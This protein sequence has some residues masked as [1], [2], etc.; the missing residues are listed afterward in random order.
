MIW[1]LQ[2]ARFAGCL[3][4]QGQIWKST[5]VKITEQETQIISCLWDLTS[6]YHY[7]CALYCDSEVQTI[8]IIDTTFAHCV[9]Y[10]VA[11][12]G[13]VLKGCGGACS[14]NCH[15]LSISGC[16]CFYCTAR[17]YE[18]FLWV[19]GTGPTCNLTT[20]TFVLC[21]I[22]HTNT[23][24]VGDHGGI[25]V[26]TAF[27]T[28]GSDL[29]FTD[30]RVTGQGAA[31]L[32]RTGSAALTLTRLTVL[33]CQGQ[34][35]IESTRS[36][37]P[38]ISF[39][40]FYECTVT[41]RWVLTGNSS[42]M[43]VKNCVF[44]SN[45]DQKDIGLLSSSVANVFTIENCVFSGGFP[46]DGYIAKTDPNYANVDTASYRLFA[47][48]TEYCPAIPL[49]TPSISVRASSRPFTPTTALT[50]SAKI[51]VSSLFSGSQGMPPS[52]NW[53]NTG[54]VTAS[55]AI[56][57]SDS[58]KDSLPI[59]P[60]DLLNNSAPICR[61]DLPADSAPVQSSDLFNDSVLIHASDV[62][63]DSGPVQS[64]DLFNDSL[65][66]HASDVPMDSGPIQSSD[67]F[68]DS[69]PIRA[70]DLPIDSVPIPG[71]GI[72]FAVSD[73]LP[74]SSQFE[75]K[76]YSGSGALPATLALAVTG[77][78]ANRQ[79]SSPLSTGSIVGI[80][81]GCLAV[82]TALAVWLL[83]FLRAKDTSMDYSASGYVVDEFVAMTQ[84]NM[85]TIQFDDDFGE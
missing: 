75:S 3:V 2:L 67:L 54:P 57:A 5:D 39:C 62:P 24:N 64:S 71:S 59:H 22:D 31:I 27:C 40:N 61:S 72:L 55:A 53:E 20:S 38:T 51:A 52:R 35:I 25:E 85:C 45:G 37:S 42:G 47:M 33:R 80:I 13:Y 11:Q 70:S 26:H 48:R 16:C 50:S 77:K 76:R 30:S 68:T 28:I 58:P 66:I 6:K 65:L 82:L 34:S 69:V 12:P 29:N 15:S 10:W 18:Q 56:P 79:Q 32:A 81:V 17:Y 21:G 7:G 78:L 83:V 19:E 84:Q 41:T 74:A 73:V 1:I 9:T 14:L 8:S 49:A 44:K 4:I 36:S 23:N 63:M 46:V 43:A 60:S